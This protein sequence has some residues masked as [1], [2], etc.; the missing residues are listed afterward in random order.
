MAYQ[1]EPSVKDT[2]FVVVKVSWW[3]MR[4]P[5]QQSNTA[6]NC[7]K[8]KQQDCLSEVLSLASSKIGITSIYDFLPLIIIVAVRKCTQQASGICRCTHLGGYSGLPMPWTM[9][10]AVQRLVA[11]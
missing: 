11:S 9:G 5:S 10:A 7:A 6:V 3:L 1:M 8:K 2:S 4:W